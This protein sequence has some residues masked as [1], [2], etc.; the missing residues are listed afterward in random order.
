MGNT[1][2]AAAA[3]MQWSQD[4]P[5][6]QAMC[7]VDGRAGETSLSKPEDHESQVSDTELFTLLNFGFALI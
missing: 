3:G 7:A 2:K 1:T 4:E 5:R 6:R